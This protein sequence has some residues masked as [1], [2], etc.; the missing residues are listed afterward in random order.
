LQDLDRNPQ[1]L[2][3]CKNTSVVYFLNDCHYYLADWKPS[4]KCHVYISGGMFSATPGYG[5]LLPFAQGTYDIVPTYDASPLCS[6]Q[7]RMT[8]LSSGDPYVHPNV[9][10][11][12][13]NSYIDYGWY[14]QFNAECPGEDLVIA[15]YLVPSH[16]SYTGNSQSR[17]LLNT[18]KDLGLKTRSAH[19][20]KNATPLVIDYVDSSPL[21]KFE[22]LVFIL[23]NL[24]LC[25]THR[26][27][28]VSYNMYPQF[29]FH[30][31]VIAPTLLYVA[32]KMIYSYHVRCQ[33]FDTVL[34]TL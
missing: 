13:I 8:T 6:T 16:L 5:M 10:V 27:F 3:S 32:I 12:G 28:L 14:K 9:Y 33:S 15:K 26:F 17:Y 34:S 31:C 25:L 7:V 19:I 1:F 23:Y 2:A 18:T 11:S 24:L 21:D 30:I 20:F 29:F 22:D 4:V